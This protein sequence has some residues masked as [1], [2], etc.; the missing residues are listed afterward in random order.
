MAIVEQQKFRRF[1]ADAP[2][3]GVGIIL[4]LNGKLVLVKRAREPAKGLWTLPGGL[5][6]LGETAREAA[7]REAREELGLNIEIDQVLDVVDYIEKDE[8]GRVRIHYVLIDFLAYAISGKLQPGSDALEI[9]TIDAGDLHRLRMPELTRNFLTK[10]FD[11]I[12][13][14]G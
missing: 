8:Q 3:I 7:K 5:I 12:F 9:K 13:V 6:E 2:R 1:Y 14:W 10:Y 11:R 4:L